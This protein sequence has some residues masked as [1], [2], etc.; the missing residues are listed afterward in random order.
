MFKKIKINKEKRLDKSVSDYFDEDKNDNDKNIKCE[1]N[2]NQKEQEDKNAKSE[3]IQ[4][5]KSEIDDR[6]KKPKQKGYAISRNSDLKGETNLR[7]DNKLHSVKKV[8]L[9]ETLIENAKS[10]EELKK[11]LG[12]NREEIE[13]I[14]L[15]KRRKLIEFQK[16]LYTLPENLNVVKENY[17]DHVDNIVKLSAAGNKNLLFRSY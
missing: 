11:L 10:P 14:Q 4:K 17:D 9:A 5:I 6:L 16:D 15:E 2:L 1:N 7:D 13:K 12:T 8:F 3:D